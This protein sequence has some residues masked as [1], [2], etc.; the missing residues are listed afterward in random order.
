MLAIAAIAAAAAAATAAGVA[1]AAVAA[2]AAVAVAAAAAVAI[3][4]AAAAAT[5]VVIVAATGACLCSPLLP[6]PSAVSS[7]FSILPL[8]S[9]SSPL[10]SPSP[11]VWPGLCSFVPVRGCLL[12]FAL[13]WATCPRLCL[14]ARASALP[15]GLTPGSR[16]SALLFVCAR[17]FFCLVPH[18]DLV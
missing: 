7:P 13:V 17:P 1:V 15:L 8:P 2:T 9:S 5:T 18:Q 10:S 11:L 6:L 4:A 12:S 16:A 3:V 14:Y